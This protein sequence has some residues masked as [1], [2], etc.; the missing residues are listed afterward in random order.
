MGIGTGER[1]SGVTVIGVEGEAW[2]MCMW[3]GEPG[4]G[5][6]WI[7]GGG[8]GIGRK[9]LIGEGVWIIGGDDD[10]G[11][12]CLDKGGLIGLG[13]DSGWTACERT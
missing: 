10:M 3:R 12:E 7:G 11:V 1:G 13:T 6:W 9:S 4:T 8:V 5:S 2:V